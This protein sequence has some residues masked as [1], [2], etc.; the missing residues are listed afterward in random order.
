MALAAVAAARSKLGSRY[1]WG[2]QGP[3]TFDCSGLVWWAYGQAGFHGLPRV[4]A[5]QYH[6][7]TPVTDTRQLLVGDLLFFSTT[8]RSDWTTISHVGIYYGGD[9]MIEAPNSGKT[10]KSGIPESTNGTR[11]RS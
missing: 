3:L 11:N 4:A 2:T 8:S 6:A 10:L 5:D 1:V 7:T 9:F